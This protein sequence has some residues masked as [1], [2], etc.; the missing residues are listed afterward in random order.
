M[1]L[2]LKALVVCVITV[3]HSLNVQYVCHLVHTCPY[4]GG[5]GRGGGG[6][7]GTTNKPPKA[8]EF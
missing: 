3:Y 2:V 7:G 5:G 8:I 6:G 1:G 4:S